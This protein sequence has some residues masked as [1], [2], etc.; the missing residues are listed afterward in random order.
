M[1]TAV[2]AVFEPEVQALRLMD[3]PGVVKMVEVYGTGQVGSV[4]VIELV[5]GKQMDKVL[6]ERYPNQPIP[7][8][9]ALDY[10]IKMAKII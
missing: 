8:D 6:D 3:N 2:R 9:V 1:E 4:I 7:V 10:M 5:E